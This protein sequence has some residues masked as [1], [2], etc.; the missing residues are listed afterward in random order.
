[1]KCLVSLTVLS[2]LL[3]AV[4]GSSVSSQL[5]VH[6][7]SSLTKPGGYD[8]R[9]ALFGVPPYGGSIQQ[10]VYY[11]DSNLCDPN[12]DTSGGFP[13]RKD[14]L[15][16]PSPYILMVDRGGCSF[17]IK[18]RNA[19]RSGAAAVI[20]ADFSCLCSA[21]DACS[22]EPGEDCETQEPY[23]A[24]DGSGSDITIPSFLMFKQD[25]DPVKEELKANRMVRMEMA[26]S[27]PAPDSRVEY[28][29]WTT[30]TDII[31]R[32]FQTQFK[33]AA[34]ALGKHAYF[35]PH[36]YIYDGVMSGCRMTDGTDLCYNLC[37]NDGRYCATD[38]DNDLDNGISGA[39][40]VAES[41]RR[42]C[43]WKIYGKGDG[44]GEQWWVYGDE[45]RLRC[46]KEEFF[47]DKV[48]IDDAMSH[49]KIDV[50]RVESCMLDTGGLEGDNENTLLETQLAA[51]QAAGVVIMPA[52]FVNNA[53]IRGRLEFSTVFKAVCAG[54]AGGYKPSIC[55]SCAN[56][57]DEYACVQAGKCKGAS[58]GNVSSGVF[59]L[60][61]AS[62]VVLFGC[63]A[64]IQYRRQQARM[65]SEVRGILAQYMP[66]DK[67]NKVE[68]AV[69]DVDDDLQFTIS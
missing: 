56:C 24:D 22:S 65:H 67:D 11:S 31:S 10:N 1:M 37:T 4:G 41:L 61:M 54:Y 47:T 28:E 7:P 23:M 19:Q 42:L 3:N 36:M 64:M 68:S 43:I 5:Q 27:L 50:K 21:G 40:V 58:T 6:I 52:A 66:L 35:T 33:D 18:V 45:F 49:A 62:V 15:P 8:H 39:D 34:T 30:P 55:T 12:V 20:I 32:E 13:E 48:C 17:V 46:D 69:D 25:A 44:I 16:W 2:Q 59:V 57:S 63:I 51:K 26:W 29:V 53:A 60:S 14:G 38:P 9:E